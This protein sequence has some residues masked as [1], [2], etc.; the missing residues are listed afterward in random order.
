VV[1][2]SG[3]VPDV[4]GEVAH[5]AGRCDGGASGVLESRQARRT[6]LLLQRKRGLLGEVLTGHGCLQLC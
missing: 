4:Q 3:V 1:R 5:G 2:V 6:V